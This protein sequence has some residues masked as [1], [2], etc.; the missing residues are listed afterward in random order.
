LTPL[1]LEQAPHLSLENPVL[2]KTIAMARARPEWSSISE[3][4][5]HNPAR[6]HALDTLVKALC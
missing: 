6:E 4:F 2:I 1:R 3:N 5:S